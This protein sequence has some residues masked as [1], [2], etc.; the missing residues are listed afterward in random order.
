[1]IRLLEKRT[2]TSSSR[3]AVRAHHLVVLAAAAPGSTR[4]RHVHSTTDAEDE[5]IPAEGRRRRRKRRKHQQLE[6]EVASSNS[7]DLAK[8]PKFDQ[9]GASLPNNEFKVCH[10]DSEKHSSLEPT[11]V[12]IQAGC[13]ASLDRNVACP[14][15]FWG[16]ACIEADAGSLSFLFVVFSFREITSEQIDVHSPVSFYRSKVMQYQYL[17]VHW[18]V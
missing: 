12:Q 15:L 2:T 6:E 18:R 1:M 14:F 13:C 17:F 16:S 9:E 11:K 4:R 10:Q 8:A 7:E 5:V 3:P